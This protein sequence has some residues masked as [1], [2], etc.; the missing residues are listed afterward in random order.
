MVY[1][2][3]EEKKNAESVRRMAFKA[4]YSK[5][6]HHEAHDIHICLGTGKLKSDINRLRYATP[7]FLL[8]IPSLGTT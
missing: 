5:R 6:E 3:G 7:E 8:P 1:A 2:L 4:H